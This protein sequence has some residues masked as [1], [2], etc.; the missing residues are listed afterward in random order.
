MTKSF[1]RRNMLLATGAATLA[2]PAV[3]ASQAAAA[4]PPAP[5]QQPGGIALPAPPP[6]EIVPFQVHLPQSAIDDLRAR[7]AATRLPDRETDTGWVQ[8]AP[9]SR[10]R[11]LL[12]Y[13]QNRYDWRRFERQLNSLPQFRTTIDRRRA[14]CTRNLELLFHAAYITSARLVV[15]PL[16]R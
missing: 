11:D 3:G 13:W 1:T 5:G 15:K 12:G 6:G 2:V 8:G 9:L 14:S 16:V 7:L 4:A 10:V